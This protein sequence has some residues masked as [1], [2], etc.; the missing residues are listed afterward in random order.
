VSKKTSFVV[1]GESPG[2]KFD[3]AVQLGV[4]ILH[5]AEAF[6]VLLDQGPEAAAALATPS[7]ESDS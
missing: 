5:G 4:P 1:V 7:A 3:K 2:S 6:G